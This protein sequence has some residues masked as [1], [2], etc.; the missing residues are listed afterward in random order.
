[1]SNS[2]VMEDGFVDSVLDRYDPENFLKI[3]NNF[4]DGLKDELCLF[5]S[6]D[7]CNST[8]LKLNN[9][10]WFAIVDVLRKEKFSG[11]DISFWK[12]NGDEVIYKRTVGSLEYIC[13]ILN[14]VY[15]FL[16]TLSQKM[17]DKE[18]DNYVKATV[19]LARIGKDHEKYGKENLFYDF[20]GFSEYIGINID[21]GFRLTKCSSAQRVVVD[22]KIVYFMLVAQSKSTPVEI[23][24][25][26]FSYSMTESINNGEYDST[27]LDNI[28]RDIY[29]VGYK[30]CKGIWNNKPYPVFWFFK[31]N[32]KNNYD[33]SYNHFFNGEHLLGK[34]L[35]AIDNAEHRKRELQNVFISAGVKKQIER[36]AELLKLLG[37]VKCST[38]SHANLYYMVA[39]VHT[40]MRKV[41]IGRRSNQRKHL[42]GVWDFGNVKYQKVDIV[43]TIKNEYKNIFGI[44]IDIIVDQARDNNLKPFGYCTIYRNSIPHNC[45]L[46]IATIKN[47]DNMSENEVVDYI[48]EHAKK[49]YQ[50]IKFVSLND[51]KDFRELNLNEIRIDSNGDSKISFPLEDNRCV[52]Y[53]EES[54]KS[55]LRECL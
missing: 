32:V 7:I 39:C 6:F 16:D 52:M 29:F 31:Q 50:D 28:I 40:K 44:D 19:W 30:T 35:E 4:N 41:L 8:E 21:E 42:R 23:N 36:E 15:D 14:K 26:N 54:I 10:N 24:L 55:A 38:I 12:F 51:I 48:K 43:E 47:M 9:N 5:I 20:D 18:K 46:L 13:K 45:L 11:L 34:E 2:N 1:M 17:S 53:F 25:S 22:P 33:L 37:D 27:L 49:D 3:E